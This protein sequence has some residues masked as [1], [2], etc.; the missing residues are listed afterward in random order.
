MNL[1]SLMFSLPYS[2]NAWLIFGT[3]PGLFSRFG[4]RT[5]FLSAPSGQAF[6]HGAAFFGQGVSF[7]L[8]T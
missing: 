2:K 4:F 5:Y 1:R 8:R 6:V 3:D 7:K